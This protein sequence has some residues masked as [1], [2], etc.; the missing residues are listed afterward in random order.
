M[1]RDVPTERRVDKTGLRGYRGTL[2]GMQSRRRIALIS[3]LLGSACLNLWNIDFPL[4]YHG[5][6]PKK[7]TFVRTG[8]QDFHHPIL[9]L[10]LARI[11]NLAIRV[12]KPQQVA[13]LGRVCSAL[14]GV[15]IVY[16]SYWL[17]KQI[18]PVGVALLSAIAVAVSPILVIHAHYFKED[19]VF[20]AGALLSLVTFIRFVRR[21]SISTATQF[22]VATGLAMAGHY[23]SLLLVVL[24]GLFPTFGRVAS[25]PK[26]YAYLLG[27]LFLA[28][29]IF[30]MINWPLLESPDVFSEGVR[31]EADHLL[32]G[33][34]LRIGPL[35]Y[36]FG[37]HLWFSLIPGMTPVIVALGMW[38]IVWA[39]CHWASTIA[40][41][42]L[43]IAFAAIF[44]AAP[45]II[46]LKPEPDF[47][48]YVLPLVPVMICLACRGALHLPLRTAKEWPRVAILAA[49]ISYCAL[50]TVLLDYFLGHD[51]RAAAAKWIGKVRQPV[52]REHY[53]G[54]D[55]DLWTLSS[56]DLNDVRDRGV[57]Y[58]I[59]SSFMYDRYFHGN[60]LLGQDPFVYSGYQRYRELFAHPY[61]EF[62]P[63][64]CSFA[65]SNPTIRVVDIQAATTDQSRESGR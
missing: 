53:S 1:S 30:I 23:K 12:N 14:C 39:I 60:E 45:E 43:L 13:V 46:P 17:A 56:I 59:A 26:F 20:T 38:Q 49:A 25:I 21:M 5:D 52:L 50:D 11:A 18:L 28:G 63:T 65:F 33:H 55:S 64:Y 29:W 47:A 41:E 27:S 7:V 44:Y 24:F 62:K 31:Y 35:T 40:E 58:V 2:R 51:T 10:Q 32:R 36:C 15:A 48:R 22:G 34:T 16:L 54:T 4:G 19:I 37:F 57:R 9:M 8:T 61:I 42:R 6:E 3:I